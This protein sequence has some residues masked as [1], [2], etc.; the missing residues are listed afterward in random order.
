MN[1]PSWLERFPYKE[2]VGGSSPS[3][4]T[5]CGN[6]NI[7]ND[8]GRERAWRRRSGGRREL[9][10]AWALVRASVRAAEVGGGEAGDDGRRGEDRHQRAGEELDVAAEIEEHEVPDVGQTA[11]E[12]GEEHG[13]E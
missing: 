13:G 5:R 3:A 2:D 7:L 8:R 1:P 11:D 4:P 9:G 10:G 6:H 12:C